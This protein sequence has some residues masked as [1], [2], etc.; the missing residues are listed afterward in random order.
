[1]QVDRLVAQPKSAQDSTR[2]ATMPPLPLEAEIPGR[3]PSLVDTL[4]IAQG[5]SMLD[6]LNL[7]SIIAQPSPGTAFQTLPYT[8]AAL[9][10][11]DPANHSLDP[12][13]VECALDQYKRRHKL[14]ETLSPPTPRLVSD[15]EG[16]SRND[17]LFA[18]TCIRLWLS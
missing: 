13:V 6:C 7:A 14:L 2:S 18:S 10:S 12:K 16:V 17:K 8:P 4:R 9:G 5:S 15:G 11:S 3:L 1:M